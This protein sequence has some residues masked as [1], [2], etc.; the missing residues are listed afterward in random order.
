MRILTPRHISTEI[1]SNLRIK[2]NNLIL[3]VL[4]LTSKINVIYTGEEFKRF[5]N[6]YM[7]GYFK[8]SLLNIFLILIKNIIYVYLSFRYK[9]EVFAAQT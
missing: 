5:Y 4:Y 2:I 9:L 3:Q 6:K 7:N 1:F 8:D